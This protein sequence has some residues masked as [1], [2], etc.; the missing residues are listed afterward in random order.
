MIWKFERT[1]GS[2]EQGGLQQISGSLGLE[3]D[4]LLLEEK[5]VG[6]TGL[7]PMTSTL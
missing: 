3:H 5:M 4:H 7:E 6:A 1:R 2:N